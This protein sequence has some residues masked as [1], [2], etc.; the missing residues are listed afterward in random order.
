MLPLEYGDV[1][2]G[3]AEADYIIEGTYES[4]LQ[5]NLSPEP[6]PV[7]CQWVGNELTCWTSTQTPQAI[8]EELAQCLDMP[9]SNIR[10]I[11]TYTV[12]GYGGK[13]PG[14]I[15]VLTALLAKKTGRPVKALFTR[16]E[17]F[18]A[19]HRRIDAKIY[20]RLGVKKGGRITALYAK[21]ISNYG[22][23]SA[24]GYSIPANSAATTCSILYQYPNSRFEG[25]HVITNIEDHGAMNGF[26]DPEAGFCIER[27]M[28]EAAEKI[29]MDPVEFRLKNCARYGDKGMDRATA[30]FGP[31]EWS[32]LGPDVDSFPECIRK[33][34]EKARWKEKWK[35][36]ETPM[37]VREAKR[38]GI[39][40]AIG[41]HHCLSRTPDS[42]TVKMNQDGTADVFSSDPEIGQGLRTAMGQVVAEV[43]GLPY[44]DVNV[45]LSDTSVTPYGYGV[46]ASRG[47]LA[48]IGA[49][50]KAALE[51]KRQ[52]LEIA[53]GRLGVK[54]EEMEVGKRRIFVKRNPAKGISIAEACLVGFQVTG[55]ARVPYPWIDERSGKKISPVSVVA[56]IAEVEVDTETGELDLLR[57]TSAHDCGRA[58]NPTIAENQIDM[59][60][61]LANGWVRTE[62]LV[63]DKSTGVIIN[64]NMLDYKIMTILDMPKMDD[65]QE[66]LVEFP[67]P[68]GAFGAKGMS[69]TAMTTAAPAIANAIY[70]A[71]GVRV[72]G[73]HLTPN[74]ILQAMEK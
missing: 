32:V 65:I 69:E 28:D 35:G 59:S 31:V 53:A 9:L 15:S 20:A 5:H 52:L 23:D 70:N 2:K 57:L 55:N 27:L 62:E 22:R 49:A 46:F 14:K 60:L 33:V 43:L 8:R 71:I 50:Y 25:Y 67:N 58:I 64:P 21:M 51:V 74:R 19:T 45:L 44:E 68:W 54:P 13:Q 16:E 42:A 37:E 18:I 39:G 56:T 73:D 34:A 38:R 40:I 30:E 72:R 26:G 12:G 48:G 11:S 66:I 7:I 63:I 6:R 17:D 3:F 4:P 24:F 36:W 47:T 61:T 41:M 1:D 29:G 10:V